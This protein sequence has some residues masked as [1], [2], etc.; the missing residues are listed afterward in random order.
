MTTQE[1]Y[2][3][4]SELSNSDVT[5]V[6]ATWEMKDEVAQLSLFHSLVRMGDSREVALMTTISEKYKEDKGTEMYEIAFNS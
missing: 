3:L 4:A 2:K 5:N 1:I 6:L